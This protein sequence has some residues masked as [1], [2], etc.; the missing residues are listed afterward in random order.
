MDRVE[1]IRE[2]MDKL[3]RET[4]KLHQSLPLLRAHH[5]AMQA[6]TQTWVSVC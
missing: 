3:E 1:R 4:L 6:S 2:T 5:T